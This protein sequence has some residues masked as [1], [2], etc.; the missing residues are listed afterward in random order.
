MEE[1]G[2]LFDREARC[3]S[4]SYPELDFPRSVVT[5]SLYS[6]PRAIVQLLCNQLDKFSATRPLNLLLRFPVYV[7]QT[8]VDWLFLIF[9][10]DSLQSENV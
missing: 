10:L 1:I 2:L 3:G 5:S 7:R 4:T 9:F 6:H 8:I